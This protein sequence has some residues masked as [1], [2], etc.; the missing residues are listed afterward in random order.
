MTDS[1]Q[2]SVIDFLNQSSLSRHLSILT[3]SAEHC[4]LDRNAFNRT[5]ITSGQLI[6]LVQEG[7][8]IEVLCRMT[9]K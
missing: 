3:Q 5:S 8:R 2:P 9:L 6:N 1:G 4:A 7:E